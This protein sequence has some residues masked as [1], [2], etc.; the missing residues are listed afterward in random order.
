MGKAVVNVDLVKAV[1]SQI[2]AGEIPTKQE[3]AYAVANSRHLFFNYLMDNNIN[4]LN[5]ILKINLGE[6]VQFKPDRKQVEGIISS[7][8]RNAENEKIQAILD[9]FKFDPSVNNYTN[10]PE[11]KLL[12]SKNLQ[13]QVQ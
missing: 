10:D 5:G 1:K 11:F 12:L 3:L 6:N 8:I 7:Y 4:S 9:N 13:T 2:A